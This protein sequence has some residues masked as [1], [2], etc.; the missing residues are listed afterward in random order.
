MAHRDEEQFEDLD[1]PDVELDEDEDLEDV[2]EETEEDE[3]PEVD[4]EEEDV[5]ELLAQRKAVRRGPEDDSDEDDVLALVSSTDEP[6]LE[7]LPAKVVPLRDRK[8][9]IC[10]SCYLVKAKSQ[11]ADPERMLCRDCV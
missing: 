11:L 5:D 7:A 8:E 1:S 4:D 3:V 9:F 6:I 2:D 10:K